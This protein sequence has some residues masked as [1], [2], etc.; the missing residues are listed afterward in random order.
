MCERQRVRE[1]TREE[2]SRD[3]HCNIGRLRGLSRRLPVLPRTQCEL[4]MSAPQRA[5]HQLLSHPTMWLLSRHSLSLYNSFKCISTH[6]PLRLGVGRPLWAREPRR[7]GFAVGARDGPMSVG[8]GRL[9]GK[10]CPHALSPP[11]RARS[12][13]WRCAALDN[14][15]CTVTGDTSSAG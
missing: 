3:S 1:L 2:T 10:N 13:A 7:F 15:L 12:R 8:P 11:P 5:H 9:W 4:D 14:I 6:Q